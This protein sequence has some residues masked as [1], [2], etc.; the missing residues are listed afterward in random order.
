M[1]EALAVFKERVIVGIDALGGMIATDAWTKVTQI[2][3]VDFVKQVEALGGKTI[4]YTDI[5]K[6]GAL[7]GPNLVEIEKI[8]ASLSMDVIASGGISCL[9]DIKKLI[10]L[11]RENLTG[12]V[13]GK[14]LYEN[15]IQLKD[16]VKICSQNA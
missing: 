15:K 14:A 3:A 11:K 5:A 12:V 13:I 9:E 4:I 16:A 10:D 8:C 6:D 2:K 7:K 1:E